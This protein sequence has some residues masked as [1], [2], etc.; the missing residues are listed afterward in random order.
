MPGI[1]YDHIIALV[2]VGALFLFGVVVLPNTSYVNML[3]V[4]EQQ[5]RNKAL[6]LLESMLL[7]EGYPENWGTATNF[8]QNDVGRFGLALSNGSSYELDPDKVQRLRNNPLGNI[9]YERLR[10]LLR[11]QGYGLKIMVEPAFNVSVRD[12]AP[13][14]PHNLTYEVRVTH[15]DGTPIPKASVEALILYSIKTHG[16][17]Y[18]LGCENASFLTDSLGKCTLQQTLDDDVSCAFVVW[19]V[20]VAEL[21]VLTVTSKGEAPDDV[22]QI[23]MVGDYIILTKPKTIPNGDVKIQSIMILTSEGKQQVI[24]NGT[25]GSED[26]IN[27]G[28]KDEW[29]KMF[30]GLKD[31]KPKLIILNAIVPENAS[32]RVGKL[33][34]GSPSFALEGEALSYGGV[35]PGATATLERAV[36][37]SGSNYVFRLVLWKET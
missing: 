12:L 6:D 14:Q 32:G 20:Q 30:P 28:S 36:K 11:L 22:A 10:N 2:V 34:I 9:T 16:S 31:K 35:P 5:L 7:D 25:H 3:Y 29:T 33:A 4:N 13:T 18:T 27:W 24:Y 23:N 21:S 37:I 1:L 19:E 15:R 17:D 26:Q 8:S